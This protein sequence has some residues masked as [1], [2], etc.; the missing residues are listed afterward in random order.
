MCARFT[1]FTPGGVLA[2]RFHLTQP[3]DLAPRYNIAPSQPIPVIGT[4]AGGQGR[5][6]A[7]FRWGFTPHWAEADSGP[8]PV[9][10]RIETVASSP[11]F[12]D[13]LRKRRCLVPA[14]GYYEW[15][16]AGRRKL[17]VRFR[18]KDG[19]PFAFA[20]VWDVWPGPQG[21]V[22]SVAILTTSPNELAATVHDRMPAILPP[23]AEAA[24]L[25]PALTDPDRLLPLLAPYPAAEMAADPANPALNKSTFEGPACLEVPA[26]VA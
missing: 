1:L 21:K 19:K 4:K 20:G 8:R 13:A 17:P 6:L 2:E 10:A 15:R 12:G 18:L 26:G 9:N 5:G 16:S 23:D 14:D 25:D 24:W 22:F 11:V 3:P 7:L